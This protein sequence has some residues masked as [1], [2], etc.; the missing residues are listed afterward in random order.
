MASLRCARCDIFPQPKDR[1]WLWGGPEYLGSPYC[2]YCR[3]K[4]DRGEDTPVGGTGTDRL[5]N[6]W[7]WEDHVASRDRGAGSLPP[8]VTVPIVNLP[9]ETDDGCSI[10]DNMSAAARRARVV[11]MTPTASGRAVG[12]GAPT[13]GGVPGRGYSPSSNQNLTWNLRPSSIKFAVMLHLPKLNGLGLFA[14][15]KGPSGA[16]VRD[17]LLSRAQRSY[18][19][20]MEK[21]PDVKTL[22]TDGWRVWTWSARLNAAPYTFHQF[23]EVYKPGEWTMITRE[24]VAE[25]SRTG[26]IADPRGR[27]RPGSAS[28]LFSHVA[29]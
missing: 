18:L 2:K 6:R 1:E 24:Q 23:L 16:Y 29:V 7:R 17:K 25:A 20:T 3:E 27:I 19:I 22:V 5:M 10:W 28:A 14:D 9:K 21:E 4:V 13:S 15:S 8:R 12:S 11:D 26:V